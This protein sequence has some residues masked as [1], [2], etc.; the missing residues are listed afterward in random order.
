MHTYVKVDY[1]M[2]LI[3]RK[4]CIVANKRIL[5]YILYQNTR[6]IINLDKIAT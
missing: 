2:H 3:L 6:N 1:I 4:I 5:F